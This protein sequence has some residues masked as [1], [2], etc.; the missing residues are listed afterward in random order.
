MSSSHKLIFKLFLPESLAEG[1]SS[2]DAGW[3]DVGYSFVPT[4]GR[5]TD[6]RLNFRHHFGLTVQA[7]LPEHYTDVL[8]LIDRKSPFILSNPRI[9]LINEEC[10]KQTKVR[11]RNL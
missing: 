8:S 4:E 1:L 11:L 10:L 6:L 7:K 5:P 9:S 3:R 2:D